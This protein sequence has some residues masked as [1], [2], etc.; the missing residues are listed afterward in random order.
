MRLM[1]NRRAKLA[2]AFVS[3]LV[4]LSPFAQ[5]RASRVIGFVD[6]QIDSSDP[7]TFKQRYVIDSRY[8]SGPD[9]PVLYF[10][11]NEGDLIGLIDSAGFV[12]EIARTLGAH[13][14]ALEHRYYGQSI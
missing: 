10:L 7:A 12:M 6:R 3:L 1:T 2:Y 11:G 13:F 8:A 5:A 4:L 14:V 9:A